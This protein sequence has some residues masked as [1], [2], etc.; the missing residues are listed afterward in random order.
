[1]LSPLARTW[2][3]HKLDAVRQLFETQISGEI[4]DSVRKARRRT[5]AL[6]GEIDQSLKVLK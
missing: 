1:M 4:L 6:L 5:D 2:L 3:S